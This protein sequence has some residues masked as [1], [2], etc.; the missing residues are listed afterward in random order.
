M[1]NAIDLDYRPKA[2]FKP[3][4]LT[5]HRVSRVKGAVQKRALEVLARDGQGAELAET[6]LA[7]AGSSAD[8]KALEAVHPMFMGGNY[9]P[10]AQGSEVE[11]ARI[12][13]ESVTWDVVSVYARPDRSVIRYRVVDEYEGETLDDRAE[14]ES[15]QPLTLGALADFMLKAW[16]LIRVLEMNF[17]GDLD[18][19]LGFF[20]AESEFYPDLDALLRERVVVHFSAEGLDE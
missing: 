11:I 7:L 1:T 15:V 19:S 5:R 2:Y 9:L 6:L 18:A 14:M 16:S 10:D 17:E 4:K 8:R 3:Q 20:T 13:I 12:C